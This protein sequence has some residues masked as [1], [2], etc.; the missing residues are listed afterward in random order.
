MALKTELTSDGKH[1]S[2]RG[3]ATKDTQER[4]R[5]Y[6]VRHMLYKVPFDVFCK[7]GW[8]ARHDAFWAVKAKWPGKDLI[9]TDVAVP[10]SRLAEV[11]EEQ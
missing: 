3:R 8:R 9:A 2:L 1:V 4:L 6:R 7:D 10:I 5:E 11:V